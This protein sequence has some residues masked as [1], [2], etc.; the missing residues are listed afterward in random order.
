[1]V[2][3]GPAKPRSTRRVSFDS[4]IDFQANVFA[5]FNSSP[6]FIFTEVYDLLLNYRIS[7]GGPDPRNSPAHKYTIS[8]TAHHTYYLRK[9]LRWSDGK[10]RSPSADVVFSSTWRRTRT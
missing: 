4:N 2:R 9:G 8:R 5:S 1:M 6:Y 3:S 10:P 7:D